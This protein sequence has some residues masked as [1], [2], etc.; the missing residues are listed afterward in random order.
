VASWAWAPGTFAPRGPRLR[1]AG[2]TRTRRH[3]SRRGGRSTSDP[4]FF[5][6]NCVGAPAITV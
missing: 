1:V 4:L 6:G 5:A 3:R 2:D